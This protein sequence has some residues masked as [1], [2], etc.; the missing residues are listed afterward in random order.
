VTVAFLF[1]EPHERLVL[2]RMFD[3]MVEE[4]VSFAVTGAWNK[5]KVRLHGNIE[6]QSG[7]MVHGEQCS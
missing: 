3:E 5:L 6:E 4:A 7:Y 2:S 1:T